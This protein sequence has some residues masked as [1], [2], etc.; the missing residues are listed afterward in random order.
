MEDGCRRREKLAVPR[1]VTKFPSLYGI[2]YRLYKSSLFVLNLSQSNPIRAPQLP[3][4][5]KIRLVLSFHLYLGIPSD[6]FP[7]GFPARTPSVFLCLNGAIQSQ[8]N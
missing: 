7:S 5:F 6:V 1:L 3:S 2:Q 4:N 8:L